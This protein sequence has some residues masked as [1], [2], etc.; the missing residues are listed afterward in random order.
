MSP[1]S[2][3]SSPLWRTFS[4]FPSGWA[5]IALLVLRL[6][7][8]TSAT[9]EATFYLAGQ[10]SP[11]V[12]VLAAAATLAGV[13]LVLGFMTPVASALLAALGVVLLAAFGDTPSRLFDSR[14]ALFEFVAIAAALVILGPG[15]TSVDA[16]LFGLR[17]VSISGK[18]RPEDS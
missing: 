10:H 4:R 17:E 3:W 2:E 13:A 1:P 9:L 18:K 12:L 7:A 15:S 8:G 5:G 11:V 6:T 16:R 14:M